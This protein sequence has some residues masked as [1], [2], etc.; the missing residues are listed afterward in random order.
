MAN[1]G[2]KYIN[3]LCDNPDEGG[4]VAVICNMSEDWKDI[5]M[6]ITDCSGK[7]YLDFAFSSE[8]GYRQ[9]KEK[10][11][12]LRKALDILEEQVEVHRKQT[13]KPSLNSLLGYKTK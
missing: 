8:D 12:N 4:S 7:V 6:E 3:F 5:N 1:R 2:F 13:I 11:S 10:I 9:R